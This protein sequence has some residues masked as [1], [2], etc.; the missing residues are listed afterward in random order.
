M[1]G[2]IPRMKSFRGKV[3]KI[4]A[5]LSLIIFVITSAFWIWSW[6]GERWL[7]WAKWNQDA[8]LWHGTI[9]SIDA[10]QG[11]ISADLDRTSFPVHFTSVMKGEAPDGFGITSDSPFVSFS[12]FSSGLRFGKTSSDTWDFT[13]PAWVILLS[14]LVMP[15]I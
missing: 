4:S 1:V 12:Q 6:S 15:T 2:I 3:L 13:L 10:F 14:S 7:H 9:I 5:M 8:I 11:Q